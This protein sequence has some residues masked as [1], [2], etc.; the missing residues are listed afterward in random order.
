MR[1]L[2]AP[3]ELLRVRQWIKNLFVAAPLLFALELTNPDSLLKA[4]AAVFAFCL[5]ASAVYIVNDIADRK[6]DAEHPKKK[7]RPMARGAMSPAAAV[8]EAVVLL[9][10]AALV[11]LY[12]N[13]EF[14]L[15][16]GV[17]VIINVAY[18]AF[19]KRL[20][21][22][23][24]LVIA[25]G[26]V[27]RVEGGSAA[28]GVASSR[29]IILSTLFLALFL[30]LGKRRGEIAG[31]GTKEM[32]R[33]GLRLYTKGGLDALL[34]STVALTV[35]AYA[36]YTVAPE[37]VA[38]L[39][40]NYLLYTVPIVVYGLFRYYLLIVSNGSFADPTD[41]VTKDIGVIVCVLLWAVAVVLLIYLPRLVQI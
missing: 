12:V 22:I 3:L 19:L 39:G 13:T 15:V 16:L 41:V 28:I 35:I 1:H 10:G 8:V 14:G 21:L 20:V 29:W 5:G 33:P 18:T 38:R 11:A 25:V 6:T 34:V 7:N 36:L 4:V 26:F 40:T 9:A 37:T 24:V 31:L 23:D 30:G 2:A 32:G 27:L 17:Y